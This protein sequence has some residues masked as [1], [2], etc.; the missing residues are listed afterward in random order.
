VTAGTVFEG[1]RKPLRLWFQAMWYITNQK[2]GVSALGLKRVLGLGSYQ[3]AWAWLHKLR[4]SM[5][6]PGRDLLSGRVEVDE[7]YVGGEEEGVHGR[8]TET[9]A[10]V[11]IAVEVHSPK[12]FGRVRLRQ[13]PDVS[14]PSLIGFVRDVVA[15]GATVITDGWQGYHGLSKHGY[16]HERRVLSANAEP[17]HVVLPGPHRVASLLK[18]WLL[19][20]HQGAVRQRQLDYYLDEYAFRFNRRT[21]K[22]RGLLFHRLMQQAVQIDPVPYRDILA[23]SHGNPTTARE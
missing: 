7:S 21:S 9:K 10:I 11:A 19:G 5:V 12:G 17:A 6:R 2:S 1:T 23:K 16:I 15:P 18:R 3:T 20:I 4:R 8:E 13:V 14:G 22:S